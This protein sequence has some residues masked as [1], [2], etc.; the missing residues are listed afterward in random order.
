MI[1]VP[2]EDVGQIEETVSRICY[3]V[4]REEGSIP[5]AITIGLI[6]REA[7]TEEA[8]L[9]FA[10]MKTRDG[11]FYYESLER[12]EVKGAQRHFRVFL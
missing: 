8:T 2:A 4:F 10:L 7:T 12:V 3:G 5:W 6:R 1:F 11:Y 9:G